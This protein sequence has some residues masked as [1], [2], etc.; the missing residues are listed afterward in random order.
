MCVDAWGGESPVEEGDTL[1]S[2]LGVGGGE[3]E[4][5]DGGDDVG[6]MEAIEQRKQ[7]RGSRLQ[8][9]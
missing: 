4:D 7:C 5:D 1:R 9:L 6:C 3:G 8:C 2:G